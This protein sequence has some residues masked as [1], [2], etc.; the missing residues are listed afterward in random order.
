MKLI[1]QI[2]IVISKASSLELY[3]ECMLAISVVKDRLKHLGVF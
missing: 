1:L 2:L 3:L